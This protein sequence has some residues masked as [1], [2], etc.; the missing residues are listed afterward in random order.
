MKLRNK[1]T[2][3]VF[4]VAFHSSYKDGKITIGV[5][6]DADPKYPKCNFSDYESLKEF[7]ENWE[8]YKP[9]EPIFDEKIRRGIRAWWDMQDNPFKAAAVLCHEHKDLDGF[10]HWRI[11]GYI[12]DGEQKESTDLCFRTKKLY[13]YDQHHDY[14]KEELCGEEEE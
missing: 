7:C 9:T 11:F 8:D 3:N 10:Y 12:R 14:T 6:V 5:E 2:G 4:D 13:A 1:K